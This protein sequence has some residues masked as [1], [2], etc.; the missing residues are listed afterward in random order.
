MKKPGKKPRKRRQPNRAARA[1][2]YA[3]RQP[4]QRTK[5]DDAIEELLTAPNERG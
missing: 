2:L 3:K 5:R 1:V 4:K